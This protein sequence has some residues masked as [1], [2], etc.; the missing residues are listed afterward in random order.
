[1][2]ERKRFKPIYAQRT[3][4]VI[5]M[6]RTTS[7]HKVLGRRAQD[8]ID[9]HGSA[10]LRVVITCLLLVVAGCQRKESEEVEHHSPVHKPES[11]P[12][13]VD[14]LVTLHAAILEGPARPSEGL[15][16]FMETHDVIRWLPE[17]AADSDLD[18]D[19]W[20]QV[21]HTA[22]RMEA[23]LTAVLKRT[24]DARLAAYREYKDSM[25]KLQS[26]LLNLRQLFSPASESETKHSH[27]HVDA[28]GHNHDHSHNYSHDH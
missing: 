16:I 9:G 13:A 6:L 11:F 5:T 14:R 21:D 23:M 20:N 18:E 26:Q 25:D 15:D 19:S 8:F 17:L 24:G 4:E 10:H 27:S 1:M 22:Q 3:V 12:A 28:H 7:I 2:Q